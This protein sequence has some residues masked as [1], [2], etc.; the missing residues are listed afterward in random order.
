MYPS[1]DRTF[2][3]KIL[4]KISSFVIDIPIVSMKYVFRVDILCYYDFCFKLCHFVQ[5]EKI[6]CIPFASCLLPSSS[7]ETKSIL[8][9]VTVILAIYLSF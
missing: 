8:F 1:L 5:I 4:E 2:Q 9:Q 6:K 7:A 3:M